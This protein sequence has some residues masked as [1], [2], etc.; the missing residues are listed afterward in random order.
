[1]CDGEVQNFIFHHGAGVT[2]AGQLCTD[3]GTKDNKNT[4]ISVFDNLK[5]IPLFTVSSQKVTLS[6]VVN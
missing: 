2:L 4:L 3:A 1:M 6:N 5:L